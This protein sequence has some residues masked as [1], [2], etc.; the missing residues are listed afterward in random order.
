MQNS[1]E[2]LTQDFIESHNQLRYYGSTIN[3]SFKF[4]FTVY[5]SM[6]GG[7]IT[8]LSIST[9]INLMLL[10]K[11]LLSFT[12]IFGFFIVWYIIELRKYYVKTSRYIN[13]IRKTHLSAISGE[14][15]NKTG[16]YTDFEKPSYFSWSSSQV[17]LIFIL[18]FFNSVTLGILSSVC[19]IGS[20]TVG[21]IITLL[22]L[23]LH[24]FFAWYILHRYDKKSA[25]HRHLS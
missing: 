22:S 16:Y 15:K 10:L 24:I 13:E 19:K 6:V 25:T 2:F 11:T 18:S 23:G 3:D 12:V 5:I 17:L 4:M 1:S 20:F 8:I 9:G 21:C 14:F 7:S